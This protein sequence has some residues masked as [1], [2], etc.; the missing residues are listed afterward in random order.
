[1]PRGLDVPKPE[2]EALCQRHGIRRLSLFGSSLRSDV[3]PD[4]DVDLLVECLPGH[5]IGFF[6]MAAIEREL[7]ALVGR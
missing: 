7:T 3:G 5:R 2:L 6:G 4:S 1:M